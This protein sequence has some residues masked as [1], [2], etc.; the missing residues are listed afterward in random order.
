MTNVEIKYYVLSLRN[1]KKYSS[2]LLSNKS[3]E[4]VDKTIIYSDKLI[5]SCYPVIATEDPGSDKMYIVYDRREVI[6]TKTGY[7]DV[8]TYDSYREATF[9]EILIAGK[10]CKCIMEEENSDSHDDNTIISKITNS[11]DVILKRNQTQ[12]KSY[13]E[14]MESIDTY[15]Q[16]LLE[17]SRN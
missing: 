12:Y 10:I 17:K 3:S 7:E 11:L 15:T 5:L 4:Y 1:N 13:V 2:D 16:L 8:M 6:P 14:S 9:D